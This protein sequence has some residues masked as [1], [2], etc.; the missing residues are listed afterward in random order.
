MLLDARTAIANIVHG[1]DKRV[2]VFVG[3][4]SIHS[5]KGAVAFARF[6]VEN[7][8]RWPHLLIAMR[9]CFEKPRSVIEGRH[10]WRGL[11]SDPVGDGSCDIEGGINLCREIGTTILDLGIP[12]VGEALQAEV[13]N[14][15]ADMY[16]GAWLGARNSGSQVHW[17]MAS[18][19]SMPMGVKHGPNGSGITNLPNVLKSICQ[20]LTFAAQL[21]DGQSGIF[22]TTGNLDGFAILRGNSAGPNFS[23]FHTKQLYQLLER[24]GVNS[25]VGVDLSHGNA[26]H[27][28]GKK[29]HLLQLTSGDDVAR[30]I[31]AGAHHIKVIL[32]EASM[33]EG[34]H[35]THPNTIAEADEELSLTDPC[36]NP[37]NTLYLLDHLE[38]AT[39]TRF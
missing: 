14:C 29:D 26:T 25:A 3:P 8:S 4:C 22:E 2:A 21:D 28:D 20:P 16:A 7:R 13:F 15:T 11:A 39:A 34:K 6:L 23:S 37:K 35:A 5:K 31:E 24:H 38:V 33:K 32:I 12:L 1:K 19:C 30:Q 17:Q 18:G 10:H 9:A 27:P 36:L